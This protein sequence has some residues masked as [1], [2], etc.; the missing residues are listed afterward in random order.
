MMRIHP[1][2]IVKFFD[3][4]SESKYDGSHARAFNAL[5]GEELLIGLLAKY[6]ED[7]EKY[8]KFEF[9]TDKCNEEGSRNR[10]LDAWIRIDNEYLKTEIKNWTAHSVGGKSLC[11]SAN[12]DEVKEYCSKRYKEFFGDNPRILTNDSVSKVF[13]PM[14]PPNGVEANQVVPCVLFWFCIGKPQDTELSPFF[15]VEVKSKSL[16]VF[17]GSLFLRQYI[18]EHGDK[19][20]NIRDCTGRLMERLEI[21]NGML[22]DTLEDEISHV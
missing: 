1:S 3:S 22:M 21:L 9:I 11:L 5:F 18:K 13:L 14:K 20:L 6:C 19:A 2:R 16:L 4:K 10:R 12:Y 17:S 7:C 15:K 8:Q